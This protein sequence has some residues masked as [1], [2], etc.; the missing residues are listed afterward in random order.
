MPEIFLSPDP[1]IKILPLKFLSLSNRSQPSPHSCRPQLNT[2]VFAPD[3]KAKT[4]GGDIQVLFC[5]NIILIIFILNMKIEHFPF[6]L[7][8]F[9]S[10]NTLI[11]KFEYIK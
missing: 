4:G 3:F 1:K 7:L 6:T 8:K 11:K 9:L 5:L 2:F 10:V